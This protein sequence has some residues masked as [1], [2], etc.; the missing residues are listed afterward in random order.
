MGSRILVGLLAFAV[1]LVGTAYAEVQNVKVSGDINMK[2]IS[3]DNFDLKN[4]QG[5]LNPNQSGAAPVVTNDDGANFLLSSVRVKVDADLSDNVSTHVRLLNQR[6]W[7]AEAHAAGR[8]TNSINID[9]AYVVLKEFLYSPLTLMIGRQDLSYGTG[10]IVGPGLLAD[11]NG[12]FS[13]LST[14]GS[15]HGS[16]GQQ[17]SD[18]N[19]Y[20]AVRAI[21]DF[22]PITVEA[23]YAKINETGVTSNDQDLWGAVFN[24]KV[25]RWDAE[26]EP[27]FFAKLDEGA[28]VVVSDQTYRTFTSNYVY[29]PGLRLAGSPIENLRINAEGAHQFGK[30]KSTVNVEERTRNAWAA[31]VDARYTW[32]HVPWTPVTGLGWVFFTGQ[33]PVSSGT[34]LTE[35]QALGRSFTAWDLMYRGSFT[36]FIQDF[37]GGNDQAGGL[38]TTFDTNDTSAATNRHLIYGD[39]SVKPLQDVTLWGRFTHA[40]FA[41]AP[42]TGRSTYA[43]DEIDFKAMYD[44]TEDVQLTLFGGWF[45]PGRYYKQAD[46]NV[47]GHDTAWTVGT[48][49]AVKF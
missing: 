4:K 25:G 37:L 20:D 44:Y 19:T 31:T 23:L 36:T 29:T 26:V 47:A 6:V 16:I 22:A 33:K 27:Y 13:T 39:A 5:N 1:A 32:A 49:A 45:F 2:W 14:G 41:R 30:V 18:Y 10:F 38:Y 40:Q 12:T 46:P 48:A 21:F 17:Y 35:A 8:D 28:S 3:Q 43:G 42:R 11:P 24:Y 7:D 9:T 34:S 15:P